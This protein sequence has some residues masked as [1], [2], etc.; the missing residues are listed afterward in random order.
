MPLDPV[1]FAVDRRELT[2]DRYFMLI[3]AVP[4]IV[5]YGG[6]LVYDRG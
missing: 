2:V 6:R 1:N 4:H 3:K 5:P